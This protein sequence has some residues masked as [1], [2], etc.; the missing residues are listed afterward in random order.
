MRLSTCNT[1]LASLLTPLLLSISSNVLAEETP[2]A[3][4]LY[5]EPEL[6]ALINKNTHLQRVKADDCQLV[7]DIE[8]RANKMA[9]PSYQFL[10]GDMLAYN[11]CVERNVELGVYYMRKAAE[12]GLAA[13]LEQLGRY[14]DT[15]RLVQQ[16]KA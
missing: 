13:A 14:Y 9:L 8:A 1:F 11:V 2:A 3:V 10:Y 7:Q 6:I 4:P 16:D 12:Q 5:T 15:G